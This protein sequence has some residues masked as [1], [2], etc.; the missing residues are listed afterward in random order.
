MK[1]G[2]REGQVVLFKGRSWSWDR[3]EGS[4]QGETWGKGGFG[5]PEEGGG[6][7]DALPTHGEEGGVSY[8]PGVRCQ[9][10][11]VLFQRRAALVLE[12]GRME[13]L[14][15]CPFVNPD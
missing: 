5:C 9:A 1:G 3:V 15:R 4:G 13:R 10:Q 11:H 14:R 6:M 2:C 7:Q 8:L 12:H